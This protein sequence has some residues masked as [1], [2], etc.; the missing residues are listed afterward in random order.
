[1]LGLVASSSISMLPTL[2]LDSHSPLTIAVIQPR[3]D[4]LIEAV[5]FTVAL[6]QTAGAG[7]GPISLTLVGWVVVGVNLTLPLSPS[8]HSHDPYSYL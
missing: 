5:P 4:S 1:M 6:I 3:P 8:P 2:S 7:L